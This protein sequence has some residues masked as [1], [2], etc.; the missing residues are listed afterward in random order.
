MRT[1]LLLMAKTLSL[2]L[3]IACG[4]KETDDPTDDSAEDSA[5]DSAPSDDTDDDTAPVDADGD[6]AIATVDCDDTDPNVNPDAL[7]V[8]DGQDNN[9]DGAIDGDD[10]QGAGSWYPDADGDGHGVAEGAV[11]AC[12][13]P[14]GTSSV[15]GD[16]APDDATVYPGAAEVCGDGVV[17]DCAGDEASALALCEV[18]SLWDASLRIIYDRKGGFLGPLA[19]VGDLDGDGRADLAYAN[20]SLDDPAKEAGGV[21]IFLSSGALAA[22]RGV[23]LTLAD[24]DLYIFGNE[25]GLQ[26]GTFAGAAGDLDG[27]GLGD[28]LIGDDPTSPSRASGTFFVLLSTGVLASGAATSIDVDD[29]DLRI[30]GSTTATQF[31]RSAQGVGDVDGDGLGDLMLA[32]PSSNGGRGSVHLYLSSGALAGGLTELSELDADL[33][34]TGESVGDAAGEFIEAVGDIDGDGLGDVLVG[35][36]RMQASTPMGVAYLLLSSGALSVR[37]AAGTLRLADLTVEGVEPVSEYNWEAWGEAHPPGARLGDIDGDGRDDLLI[38]TWHQKLAADDTG[39]RAAIFLTTGSIKRPLGDLT[40]DDA[41]W[42]I[43]DSVPGEYSTE[44]RAVGDLDGDGG[45]EI[46]LVARQATDT[47]LY[48]GALYFYRSSGAL[49]TKGLV[50]LNDYDDVVY[51]EHEWSTFGYQLS[52]MGDLNGDGT[53]DFAVSSPDAVLSTGENGL[54]YVV[55]GAALMRFLDGGSY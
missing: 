23:D 40:T 18:N 45:P 36:L 10:A 35:A 24:A 37:G 52:P 47:M 30:S 54:A 38:H 9:C 48:Q 14:D 26:V 31:D 33:T 32:S 6:G 22:G 4:D 28:L 53:P 49:R 41:E 17:Q 16:C 25:A 3:L 29:A 21:G 7:E 2:S 19:N 11:T 55:D 5:E 27:D 50:D 44:L 1:P 8:C 42:V 51:G 20:P 43:A 13:A 15:D 39:A 34:L 46:V 12:A